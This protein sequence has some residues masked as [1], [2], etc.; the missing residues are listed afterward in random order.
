MLR[1]YAWQ[2]LLAKLLHAAREGISI[3]FKIARIQIFSEGVY[4]FV[5]YTRI[6]KVALLL[7][8]VGARASGVKLA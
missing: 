8:I 3:L 2:E 1:S 5:M 6:G 4:V 7:Q